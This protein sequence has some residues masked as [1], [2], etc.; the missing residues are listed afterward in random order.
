MIVAKVELRKFYLQKIIVVIVGVIEVDELC[1]CYVCL[2]NW[3]RS[4]I[5]RYHA[6]LSFTATSTEP[7]KFDCPEPIA[8]SGV[9]YVCMYCVLS[10]FSVIVWPAV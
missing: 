9:V 3:Q 1:W 7:C 4:F 8:C 2:G 6:L 5:S 10:V